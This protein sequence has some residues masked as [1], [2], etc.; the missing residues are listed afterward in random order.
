[1]GGLWF[2]SVLTLVSAPV[3]YHS[4]LRK[5][6]RAEDAVR[7][8]AKR[9][10]KKARRLAKRNA[11]QAAKAHNDESKSTDIMTPQPVAAE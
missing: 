7:Y 11:R 9:E 1:M 4:Y 6:R 10:A 2:A 5:E 8:A 3:L